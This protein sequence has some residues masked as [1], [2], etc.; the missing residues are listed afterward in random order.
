MEKWDVTQST[1]EGY[2]FYHCD[3]GHKL[4]RISYCIHS[5]IV[6]W[7][8][9]QLHPLLYFRPSHLASMDHWRDFVSEG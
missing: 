7:S 9:T 4:N 8:T 5:T 3:V 6:M 1:Q 2:P